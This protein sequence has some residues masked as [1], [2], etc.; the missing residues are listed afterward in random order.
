V[1]DDR[2]AA[3]SLAKLL[4]LHGYQVRVAADGPAALQA[5]QAEVPDVVLLDL[6]LPRMSGYEVARRLREQKP[7]KKPLLIAVTGYSEDAQRVHSYE[8]GIDLHLTKP[9]SIDELRG[10]LQRYQDVTQPQR[11]L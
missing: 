5:V 3:V 7:Q 4:A 6:G 1:E 2:D 10:F 11:P 9:V 8:V